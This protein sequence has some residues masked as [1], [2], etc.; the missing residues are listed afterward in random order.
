MLFADR[1]E[2]GQL[3]AKRLLHLKDQHPVVLAL[4][5][6]GVVVGYEIARALAAP[7][8][9]VLVR[10]IGAPGQPEL[11]VGAVADGEQPELVT[12]P[13]VL[14]W[15]AVGSD[16][17]EATKRQELAEIERR[18][19]LYYGERLPVEIRGRAAIVVDDGIATGA[20]MLAALRAVRRRQPA[21]VVMAVPVAP[22]SSLERLRGEA[23]EVVCLDT[24]TEFM[25]V[26]Q[27]YDR[28]SQLRDTEVIQ[29]LA[30]ARAFAATEQG[31][32][33]RDS[34]DTKLRSS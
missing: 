29:L 31:E 10:K 4:P 3:L 24:P 5:R 14:S 23:D 16:Y 17:I 30:E 28:F 11:A 8:D 22:E 32:R 1:T 34:S 15:L 25:A 18:R 21:R 6:G 12:D 33:E 7:L 27:F 13:D 9:L 2:A 19:K 20:T 26:G